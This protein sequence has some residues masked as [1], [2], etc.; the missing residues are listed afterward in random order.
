[1][2]YSLLG[3]LFRR[4]D[5]FQHLVRKNDVMVFVDFRKGFRA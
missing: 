3:A 5:L 1:L 2:K 4:R